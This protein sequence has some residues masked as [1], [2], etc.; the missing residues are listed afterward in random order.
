MTEEPG[1][2]PRLSRRRLIKLGLGGAVLLGAGGL[3]GR[4]LGGYD[5][6]DGVA[7]RLHALSPKEYLIFQ[8][9]AAR[10][11]RAD[12]EDLPDPEELEAALFVDGFVVRLA[13]ADAGDLRNLLQAM[14]HLAPLTTGRLERFTR[15]TGEAQD[16]VLNALMKSDVGMARGAFD[17]LKTLCVMAYFRHPR[18]WAAIGY[19]GPQVGRPA[20][21][22]NAA[23][24]EGT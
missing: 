13:P 17:A 4:C 16:E 20:G 1:G 15:L 2:G 6:P 24:G 19:D 12:A 3:L 14:E 5:L 8:S 21:G 22:W 9:I 18:S 10:V 7:R 23:G 11:L